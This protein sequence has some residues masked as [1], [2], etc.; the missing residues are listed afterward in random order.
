LALA[1][2]AGRIA[3]GFRALAVA[4]LLRLARVGDIPAGTLEHDADRVEQAL[5]RARKSVRCTRIVSLSI[6]A[7]VRPKCNLLS[8]NRSINL[9]RKLSQ[10]ENSPPRSAPPV[11][12]LLPVCRLSAAAAR[13][14]AEHSAR[15]T[16]APAQSFRLLWA[17]HRA[18]V[19]ADGSLPLRLGQL[20]LSRH[21]GGWRSVRGRPDR[22]RGVQVQ[23]GGT[24][25]R[26]EEAEAAG[27]VG[28][29]L[30]GGVRFQR[31]GG[32]ACWRC[33]HVTALLRAT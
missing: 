26:A 27:A 31:P 13:T 25:A 7:N 10:Y 19:S 11:R 15:R 23:S 22:V 29:S 28:Q 14:G 4:V 32:I 17:H 5:H 8:V 20:P 2:A 18:V 12:R 33:R 24:V 30:L 3:G 21:A 6:I 1:L 16:H 9:R